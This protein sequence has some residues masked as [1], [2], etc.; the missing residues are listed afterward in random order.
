MEILEAAALASARSVV[1]F[2]STRNSSTTASVEVRKKGWTE[3][4]GSDHSRSPSLGIVEDQEPLRF[5]KLACLLLRM[6][7]RDIFC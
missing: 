5:V 4:W 6:H 1:N 7:R 2:D 3:D